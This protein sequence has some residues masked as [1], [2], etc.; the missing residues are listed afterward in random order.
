MSNGCSLRVR[1]LAIR[2]LLAYSGRR[3][4]RRQDT[5]DPVEGCLALTAW[6]GGVPG[7]PLQ[8]G[9]M[10]CTPQLAGIQ[11][12][13]RRKSRRMRVST[14]FVCRTRISA[15]QRRQFHAAPHR[16]ARHDAPAIKLYSA[17]GRSRHRRRQDHQLRSCVVMCNTRRRLAAIR[18]QRELL[19]L[20]DLL[21][22]AS[23]FRLAADP[24]RCGTRDRRDFRRVVVAAHLYPGDAHAA[25]RGSC[26]GLGHRLDWAT[27]RLQVPAEPIEQKRAA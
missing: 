7:M 19:D 3:A 6:A 24:R 25:G 27:V 21:S 11:L 5:G 2:W 1:W 14:P 8:C 13:F 20:P 9:L 15:W 10:G 16:P 17:K 22:D 26:V 18:R 4:R 23:S 12:E